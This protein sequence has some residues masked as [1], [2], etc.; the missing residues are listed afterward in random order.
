MKVKILSANSAKNLEKKVNEFIERE[1]ITVLKI[2]FSSS[3]NG[4]Y[5]LVEYEEK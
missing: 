1:D 5:A 4:L 2:Q 3:I